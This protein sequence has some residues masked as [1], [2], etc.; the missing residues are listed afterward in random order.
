MRLASVDET[1]MTGRLPVLQQRQSSILFH[2]PPPPHSG[3]IVPGLTGPVV[4]E[5]EVEDPRSV[6][7]GNDGAVRL[8]QLPLPFKTEEPKKRNR[9]NA[10]PF[11]LFFFSDDLCVLS[12]GHCTHSLVV[13]RQVASG[14]ML[15]FSGLLL[16]YCF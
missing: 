8:G 11:N 3:A 1:E 9:Y 4:W 5:G 6:S 10:S 15:D 7:L 16:L 13:L 14:N 12:H 2:P